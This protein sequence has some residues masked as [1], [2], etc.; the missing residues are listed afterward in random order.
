VLPIWDQPLS[1]SEAALVL[2]GPQPRWRGGSALSPAQM[3]A[4]L[5]AGGWP[6][7]VTGFARYGLA[8][9][10]GRAHVAVPLDAAMAGRLPAEEWLQAREAAG[11]AGVGWSTWRSYVATGHAPQH[12]RRNPKTGRAEWAATTVNA[13]LAT[14]PGQGIRTDLDP[15]GEQE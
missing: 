10:R 12:D 13:W 2:G 5:Q 1:M 4:S 7:G 8:M 9:R 6:P 14:R 3:Y 11:R 15:A